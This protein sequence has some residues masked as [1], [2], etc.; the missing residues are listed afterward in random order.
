[1]RP[2]LKLLRP[3]EW[4]KNTF[5]FAAVVF[6]NRMG[7]V[8]AVVLSL[9]AFAAFCLAASSGYIINDIAD[10]SRD[11]LHPAKKDRPLASGTVSVQGALTLLAGLVLLLIGMF[12]FSGLPGRF[13]YAL[14]GY[15]CLTILYSFVLKYRM[16]L[17]VIVIATLF[18]LRAIGG[19]LAIGVPVSPWLL[20][21]TFMLCLFLGFG[22]RRCEIAALTNQHALKGHRPTLI[23][24]TPDLLTHLLSTSGGMAILTFLLYTLDQSWESPF[25]EA[26][27]NLVYTLPIVVYGVY[28]YAMLIE[29]GKGSGP[30]QLLFK[31][32]AFLIAVI[33]WIL[34]AL[35]LLYRI[36]H[37]WG[38][39]IIG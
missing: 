20:V 8:H 19:A 30:T 6:G 38:M 3:P 10:R 7:D 26:K 18:V 33:L 32:A 21:C 29:S 28:R 27:R 25:H 35:L 1:M 2:Y 5:V 16:L 39:G 24:Y 34:T 37:H 14:G 11:R 4:V 15:F 13:W 23:R 31:D 36:P 12:V 9:L 22:K 17:D